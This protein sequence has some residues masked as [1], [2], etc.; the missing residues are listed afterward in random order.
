MN[1]FN[2]ERVIIRPA[3]KADC[4]PI[5]RLYS[6]SSDGVADYIWTQLAAPGEDIIDVG[7]RRYEREDSVFSYRNCTVAVHDDEILGMLVAFPMR[8]DKDAVSADS[9]PVLAPYSVLEEDGSY[10][11]CG[12][13]FF[14]PYRGHGLG[15]RF[16]ELA[17]A[18][19]LE[20][21]LPKLSLIVFE[22]NDGAKR[23]YLRHGY[24][25]VARQPVVPHP[26]IHYTGDALLMVKAL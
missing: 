10:Y 6:I 1:G 4:R 19:A 12:M 25:E 17:E 21:G 24:R 16:L 8:V 7:Q 15:T 9:D 3:A 11:I 13:A 2:P 14:P 26:L 18:Q 5:A 20:K 23:L 22:Q